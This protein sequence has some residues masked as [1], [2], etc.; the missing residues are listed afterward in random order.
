MEKP[1]I[2]GHLTKNKRK[3]WKCF[4]SKCCCFTNTPIQKLL[5]ILIHLSKIHYS[6]TCNCWKFKKPLKS[7]I[8]TSSYLKIVQRWIN[9]KELRWN[10]SWMSGSFGGS[11]LNVTLYNRF[12]KYQHSY[13]A[14]NNLKYHSIKMLSL[15]YYS[16]KILST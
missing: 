11:V 14:W 13:V 10:F 15:K 6:L 9:L 16:I 5:K 7:L 8:P 2:R 12:T 1:I 4:F 3:V